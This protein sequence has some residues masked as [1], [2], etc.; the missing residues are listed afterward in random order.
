MVALLLASC[1]DDPPLPGERFDVRTPL[2]ASADGESAAAA[3]EPLPEGSVVQNDVAFSASAQTNHS[4]WTHRGGSAT[5]RIQHPALSSNLTRAW[6]ASIGAGNSRKA[7]IT[8]DPIV[9]GGRIFTLDARS[10]LSA[11]STGG[12]EQW[13]RNLTPASERNKDGSGGGL[14]FGG[15]KLYVTTGFG[16]L[17]AIDPATGNTIWVQGFEAPVAGAPTVRDGMIYVSSRD[18]RAFAVRADTGRLAWQ[19]QANPSASATVNGSGPAVDGRIAIFPFGSAELLGAQAG[20]GTRAW[21]TML[22]GRRRG[23]AYSLITDIS[24]DPVIV[25]G[26]VYVGTP[27][28]RIAALDANSGARIWTA[29]EGALSPVWVDG[30]SVFA[31]TDLLQLVRLNASNGELIWAVDLP[32]FKKKKPR[33]YRDVYASFGP[34]LAGGR[35]LVASDDGYLRSFDPRN[36]N[37]LSTVEIPAGAATN[38][39]I[40]NQTLYLVNTK[41]Q[42][43]AYR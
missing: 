36:G 2:A 6:S 9:A 29:N 39:V 22:A 23:R 14:A 10:Q 4:E 18:N 31:V 21:G 17:Q 32:G 12:G 3:I 25:G 40:V 5:H 24:S 30:G 11:F 35:L 20:D 13:S 8:A 42:L 7:R 41:A 15:G 33:K 34:V 1:G 26:T 37:L 19:L 16:E 38:P 27:S 28:G 43:L